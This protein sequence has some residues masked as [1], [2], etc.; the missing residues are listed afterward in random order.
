M[1][2]PAVTA[3]ILSRGDRP[4]ELAASVASVRSQLEVDATVLIV[5]NGVAPPSDSPAD[6]DVE[7]A[8][9]LGIPAARNLGAERAT[10][11]FVLFLDDDAAL[12]E[13]GVLRDA[14]RHMDDTTI[15]LIALRLVDE[16][17]NS[18]SRHV[19]RLGGRG[20][21]RPGP[22]A[23]FLGGACVVRASR[24]RDLGGY[25][26]EFFYAMEESDLALGLIDAGSRI[27]YAADL[28]VY[29]PLTDPARHREGAFRTARNRVWLA[30]RRLPAPIALAYVTSWFVISS[31]RQP[32]SVGSQMAGIRA[33]WTDRIG[34]RKPI[35]WR[36]V[37][38]LCRLGRP[39]VV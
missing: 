8:E 9:N 18:S 28:C 13:S 15:D 33:G 39:P 3:V 22:V 36:T 30:H 10:G 31:V 27:W 2:A 4:T 12:I 24:F 35:A 37:W 38:R 23:G 17:G 14:A 26:G 19:P 6:V 21:T 5:W 11:E 29:H 20:V 32:R 25:P 16:V 1:T 34:P 7:T